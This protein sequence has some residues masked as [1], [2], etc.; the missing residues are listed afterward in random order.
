MEEQILHSLLYSP[1]YFSKVFTHLK[2]THFSKVEN[3][4]IFSAIKS[5]FERTEEYPRPKEIGLF[6]KNDPKYSESRDFQKGILS[7]FKEI[8]VDSTPIHN[9]QYMVEE[10]E[11]FVKLKELQD[12]ILSSAKI[13]QKQGELT[14]IP[15]MIEEA[16]KIHF[17]SDIGH[18]YNSE[19]SERI[20]Y[21]NKKNFGYTSGIGEFDKKLG[22]FRPKTLNI[23]ASPSHGGKS[24]L[25]VHTAASNLLKKKN[26]L[27]ITLEMSELEISKR[28]DANILNIDLFELS[29]IDKTVLKS[30]FEE[31]RPQL[32]KLVIKEYPAGSMDI[33]TLNG[34]ITDLKNKKDFVPDLVIIDYIG[35]M[36]SSRGSLGTFG[37]TYSLMKSVAE[38]CHGFAKKQ[39]LP[40]VTAVQ[41][42]RSSYGNIDATEDTVS[43]SLGFVMT[44]DTLTL[45][46]SNDEM[47]KN[48]Q[49]ILSI[50]KNRN[51]GDLSK[52]LIGVNFK[53]MQ[54]F[55]AAGTI[56]ETS[57]AESTLMKDNELFE[58]FTSQSF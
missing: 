57:P 48:G 41:L 29:K 25:L 54:F 35:L 53:R 12:A 11:K 28:I 6:I 2:R 4:E 39:N 44:A 17:D 32:G 23:F 13:M 18:D 21:Y 3:A 42:N 9:L 16:L 8:F 56:E 14:Q 15:V 38:E 24:A 22:G 5:Y 30:K 46:I 10:T 58:A 19:I 55:D 47:R 51:T 34:L 37:N 43:D 20:E 36:K 40:V 50:R 27:Y 1:E 26:V 33:V 45:M 31:V 49:I 52:I 7:H